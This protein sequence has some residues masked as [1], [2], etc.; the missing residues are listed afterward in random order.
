MSN[1]PQTPSQ[2]VGPYF[3]FGLTA[4]QYGYPFT[5]VSNG[6]MADENIIGEKIAIKGKV[7]DG[8]GQPIGDAMVELWQ[9]DREGKYFGRGQNSFRGFGRSGTG[10]GESNEFEFHT[11]MPGNVGNQAPHIVA[12]VFMRGLLVHA[13]TRIYFNDHETEN[14]RDE[15]LS[16]VPGERRNTLIAKRVEVK[17]KIEYRFDIYMQGEKETVFFDV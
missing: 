1:Q 13:Y 10:D 5:A 2:T 9:A 8:E 3:A 14:G 4:E 11:I 15:V 17:G 16:S 7:F 12:I 6:V